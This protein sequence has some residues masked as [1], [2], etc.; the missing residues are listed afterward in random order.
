MSTC[1]LSGGAVAAAIYSAIQ[2]SKF[3]DVYPGKVTKAAAT[4]GF[5]GDIEA[6]LKAAATNTAAAYN[7]VVGMNPKVMQATITAVEDSYIVSFRL[8]YLVAIAFGCLAIIMALISKPISPEMKNNERAVRLE[9]ENK[10]T[11]AAV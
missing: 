5:T 4:S 7:K 11:A 10:K 3:S 1:R 9:N 2:T 8:V 6:L